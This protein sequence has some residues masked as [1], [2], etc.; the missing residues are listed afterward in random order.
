MRRRREATQFLFIGEKPSQKAVEIG[1]TWYTGQLAGK[2]LREALEAAGIEPEAQEYIN[3]FGDTP[4]ADEGLT[5]EAEGRIERMLEYKR[6]GFELV[7]MGQKVSRVLKARGVEH[8]VLVHPAAR[9][10]IRKRERYQA[11][12]REVLAA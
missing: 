1:A 4:E 5:A 7:G 3:L 8:R 10:A 6:R 12:V 2:T 9:G 11:H